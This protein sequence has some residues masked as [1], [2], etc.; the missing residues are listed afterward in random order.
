MLAGHEWS[1]RSNKSLEQVAKGF[2]LV[3]SA[4]A[5]KEKENEDLR[6]AVYRRV[7]KRESLIGP[8]G[9]IWTVEEGQKVAEHRRREQRGRDKRPGHRK[10]RKERLKQLIEGGKVEKGHLL[11]LD[12]YILNGAVRSGTTGLV[13]SLEAPLG[14][15][16]W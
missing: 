6:K 5:L 8:E 1:P 10:A 15:L 7:C 12:A 9:E 13:R 14:R 16:T 2:R 4:L 3:A 11:I